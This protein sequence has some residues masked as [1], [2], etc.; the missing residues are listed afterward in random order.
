MPVSHLIDHDKMIILVTIE[1]VVSDEDI[2]EHQRKTRNDPALDPSFGQLADLSNIRKLEITAQGVQKFTS[3]EFSTEW[4]RRAF[5]APNDVSFGF[6]RMFQM[7][8]DSDQE[9]TEVF[10]SMEGAHQWLSS[11]ED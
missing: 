7:M 2:I 11:P 10:R 3:M 1:G 9:Q 4:S 6:A 5:V 8:R